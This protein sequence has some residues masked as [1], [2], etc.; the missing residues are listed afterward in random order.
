MPE[1]IEDRAKPTLKRAIEG[2][3]CVFRAEY[4]TMPE[5]PLVHIGLGLPVRFMK[6]DKVAFAV[7]ENVA[8][9]V[10]ANFQDWVSAIEMKK[11]T[12]VDAFAPDFTLVA[13]GRTNL[14]PKVIAE[15]VESVNKANYH[16]NTI[17]EGFRDYS[18]AVQEFYQQHPEPFIW[19]PQARPMR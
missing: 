15:I 11:Y 5:Y 19:S 12:L 18:K 13:S 7:V 17:P 14:D 8:N 6:G 10:E 9:F 1:T 3:A 2:G 16:F 4:F